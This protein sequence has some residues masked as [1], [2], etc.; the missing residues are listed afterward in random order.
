MLTLTE[1]GG[2]LAA[3]RQSFRSR[4][5]PLRR[6]SKTTSGSTN[7][8]WPTLTALGLLS[9]WVVLL[10][11]PMLSGQ[12]LA[13]PWSDQYSAGY[14]FRTWGAANGSGPDMC[15]SGTRRCFG[16]LPFLGAMHG[17]VFYPTSLLRLFWPM[18]PVM[19]FGFFLHYILAG[20]FT[21]LLLRKLARR[22]AASAG[23]RLRLPA[24][25]ADRVLS[26]AGPRRQAVRLTMLPLMFLAL[27]LAIRDR[28]LEGYRL[29]A[30]VVG[31]ALLSPHKMTYYPLIASGLF[32]LYL[33]FGEPAGRSPIAMRAALAARSLRSCSA[34]A[35]R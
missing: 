28:R 4:R 26:L 20:L 31:L 18:P 14:A 25:R 33:T 2:G 5:S 23:R 3:D 15:R 29:L 30:A 17:D 24:D 13:G 16:G 34:S 7:R 19:N 11:L 10:S 21:Y 9:L 8:R 22:W 1:A 32:A 12:W 35:S 6:E 27:L